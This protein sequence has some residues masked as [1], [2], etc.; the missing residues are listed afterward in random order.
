MHM[1]TVSGMNI[2]YPD[3]VQRLL[4]SRVPLKVD[5]Q[6]S[7]EYCLREGEKVQSR[8]LTSLVVHKVNLSREMNYRANNLIYKYIQYKGV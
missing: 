5:E 6:S 4:P 7:A 8:V 1:Y 2:S 3:C